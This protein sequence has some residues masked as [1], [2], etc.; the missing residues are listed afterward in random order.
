[1]LLPSRAPFVPTRPEV[2]EEIMEIIDPLP[3][4]SVFYDLGCGDARMLVEMAKRNP[5]VRF[6]GI[7]FQFIPYL[8]ARFRTRGKNISIKRGMFENYD[9]SDATHVYAYLYPHVMDNLLPK[10]EKEL[11]PGSIVYS[12]DFE[13]SQRTGGRI[14]ALSSHDPLKLGTNLFVYSF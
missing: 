7:E 12:L 6:I 11:K 14:V 5:N 9:I 8:L 3:E 10:F 1:V 13:C 4:G 2:L